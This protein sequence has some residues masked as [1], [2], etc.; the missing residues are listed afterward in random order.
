M[1]K[2]TSLKKFSAIM[3]VFAIIVCFTG[4]LRSSYTATI[5]TDGTADVTFLYA[6]L[7]DYATGIEDSRDKLEEGLE[8][9][10][11]DYEIDEYDEDGFVGFTV[12]V[13]GIELE[14]FEEVF[15]DAFGI[16]GFTLEEDDGVYTLDWDA[17]STTDEASSSGISSDTLEQYDGYMKFVLELPGKPIDDNAT[18]SKGNTLEWDL[19]ELDENIYCEFDLSKSSSIPWGL[20]IGIIVGVIVVAAIIAVIVI[21]MKKKK[22]APAPAPVT[23]TFPQAPVDQGF[24]QPAGFPQAPVVPQTPVVPQAPVA[25][26]APEAP[27]APVDNTPVDPTV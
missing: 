4:C 24:A 26:A 27:A 25:P 22:N 16:E 14:E 5:N 19:M 18:K 9:F 11:Y 1:E 17:G 3:L 10:D 6:I 23:P 21:I 7:E 13:E 20:I 8:D 12:S 15:S 2:R